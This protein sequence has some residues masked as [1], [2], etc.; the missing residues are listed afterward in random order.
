MAR[1]RDRR[2]GTQSVRSAPGQPYGQRQELEQ[3]Q[4]AV[5]LPD[6]R[7]QL[8]QAT[9]EAQQMP[10]EPVGLGA[11]SQRPDEP[12]LAGL[13][14]VRAQPPPQ[15]GDPNDPAAIRLAQYLPMLEAMAE[16]PSASQAL[17]V[18]VLQLRA[19]LPDDLPI[20]EIMGRPQEPAVPQGGE[21]V[22]PSA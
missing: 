13:D 11:P 8:A 16:K 15:R 1:P 6:R 22:P 17:R 21:Q 20:E 4:Q 9:Q 3:A 5:P 2:G 10:F 7:A 18:F 19:S 14:Q 12:L